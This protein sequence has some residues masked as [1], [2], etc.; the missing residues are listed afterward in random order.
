MGL[1]ETF[2][3]VAVTALNAFG[4]VVSSAT[5][6]S[7]QTPEYDRTTG[8]VNSQNVRYAIKAAFVDYTESDI[9]NF[10]TLAGGKKALVAAAGIN[11]TPRADD[12]VIDGTERLVVDRASVDPAGALWILHL[13]SI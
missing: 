5:Y 12:I 3:N 11:F 8:K 2:Q 4:N 6:E 7:A 9:L 10:P 13:K 1:K